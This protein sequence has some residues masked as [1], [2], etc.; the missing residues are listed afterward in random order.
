MHSAGRLSWRTTGEEQGLGL[1]ADSLQVGSCCPQPTASLVRAGGHCL[2]MAEKVSTPP[3]CSALLYLTLHQ[4]VEELIPRLLGVPLHAQVPQVVVCYPQ[5][6]QVAHIGTL[7]IQPSALRAGDE[8]EELLRLWGCHQGG[9]CWEGGEE[10]TRVTSL[11]TTES[12]QVLTNRLKPLFEKPPRA[13]LGRTPA[14]VTS[15]IPFHPVQ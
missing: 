11:L 8:I 13:E 3:S 2:L 10:H 6:W 7:V 14:S 9:V 12:S 4:H 15:T 1:R 5:A